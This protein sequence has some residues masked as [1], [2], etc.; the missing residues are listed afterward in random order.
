VLATRSGYIRRVDESS[1]LAV[2]RAADVALRVD[3]SIGHFV[4]EGTPLFEASPADRA[5]GAWQA[6]VLRAFDIGPARTMEQD[7]EF[8]V[9]QIVD[10]ALKAIS[11]AVND[12]TTA[13]TCIDQLGRILVRAATRQPPLA[14]LRDRD[15][16]ARVVLPRTSFPR[17]LE[18]A[19]SQIGHYGKADVAVPLR[20]M[21]VLADLAGA[22]RHAPYALAIRDQARRLS[23]DCAQGF[24]DADRD[25]LN[26]RLAAVEQAAE[27]TIRR[28]GLP[29]VR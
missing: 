9:L 10:I 14:T 3:R 12:P 11:P 29:S 17:L 15:G 24:P 22:T 13:L 1:L 18:V 4:M 25:E 20:L 5:T 28:A 23:A 7:V 16:R 19:F 8:G 6:A 21:R 2:A 26:V 27:A